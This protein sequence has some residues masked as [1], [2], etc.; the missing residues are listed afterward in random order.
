MNEA[1]LIKALIRKHE[2][3]LMAC[4]IQE[5]MYQREYADPKNITKGQAEQNLGLYQ[6]R[7]K[8]IEHGIE[9]IKLYAR[10]KNIE[11]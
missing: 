5:W 9:A 8:G 2:E 3:D 6:T 10:E 11:L 4:K 7:I 1:E